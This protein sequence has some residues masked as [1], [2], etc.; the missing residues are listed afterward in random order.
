[1]KIFGLIGKSLSHS[2]S[3]GYFTSK[4]QREGI[5]DSDYRIFE[6]NRIDELP[7]LI[8]SSKE[9]CGLNVTIPYKEAVLSLLQHIDPVAEEIGA[10]NTIKIIRSGETTILTGYNTDIT[11]FSASILPMLREQHH[12]ALILGNGGASKA[13]VYVLK[14]AGL[15]VLIAARNPQPGQIKMTDITEDIVRYH[16]LIV[17][18]TPIGMHPEVEGLPDIPYN[19]ITPMH[20]VYDLIYNPEYTKFM[21]E[22]ILRDA[23]IMN[24]YQML[25]LQ[26]ETS[27]K[28]WNSEY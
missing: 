2:F 28:I 14:K 3:P 4:F 11:G 19:G 8:N 6:L 16:K 25:I 23:D 20:L 13:V 7:T 18:A 21:M 27:W 5:K 17:N 26:A 22:G 24:G 9:I 10:I 15:D 12:S 1:M